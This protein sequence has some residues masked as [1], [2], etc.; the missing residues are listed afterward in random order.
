MKENVVYNR[1][2]KEGVMCIIRHNDESL[3][4]YFVANELYLSPAPG[5]EYKV[6]ECSAEYQKVAEKARLLLHR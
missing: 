1:T 3:R 2:I 4:F 5:K 6:S